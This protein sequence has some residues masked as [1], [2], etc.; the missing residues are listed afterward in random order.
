MGGVRI[1]NI[2]YR[3]CWQRHLVF[4]Y[5]LRGSWHIWRTLVCVARHPAEG[6]L[7]NKIKNPKIKHWKKLSTIDLHPGGGLDVLVSDFA[8]GAR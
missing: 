8:T 1:Q 4:F 3:T 5:R 2:V 7:R 6:T